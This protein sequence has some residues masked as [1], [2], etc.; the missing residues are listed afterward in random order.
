MARDKQSTLHLVVK[1]G[2]LLSER[3]LGFISCIWV[4]LKRSLACVGV[5]VGV[6]RGWGAVL[7]CV[8]VSVSP[9]SSGERW[10]LPFL[11]SHLRVQQPGQQQPALPRA[12]R[13]PRQPPR[14]HGQ[15]TAPHQGPQ[16]LPYDG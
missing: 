11:H 3:R 2:V 8:T 15:E 7:M 6:F 12:Q 1:V 14:L 16:E 4:C 13:G 5:C 9:S 10:L